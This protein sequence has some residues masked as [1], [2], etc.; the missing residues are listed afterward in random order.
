MR[1][2]PQVLR[3][4][5]VREKPPVDSLPAV[6]RAVT[7]AERS[8]GERGRVLVRYSGTEKLLRVMIEGESESQIAA[9]AEDIVAAAAA[10]IGA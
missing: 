5:K 6:A 2:Y 7:A 9:L 1:R 8:L 10:A 4:L 3:N